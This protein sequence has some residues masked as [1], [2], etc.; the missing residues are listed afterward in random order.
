MVLLDEGIHRHDE[1]LGTV[2]LLLSR[3]ATER[4]QTAVNELAEADLG[5]KLGVP[6]GRGRLNSV[7]WDV[8]K[9]ADQ[10][11]GGASGGLGRAEGDLGF[12]IYYQRGAGGVGD[13]KQHSR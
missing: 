5:Q 8:R 2:L 4:T 12:S 9:L 13:W 10:G 6:S 7:W 3:H 1:R 11:V